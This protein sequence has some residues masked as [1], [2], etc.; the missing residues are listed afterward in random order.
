MLRANERRKWFRP[1][2]PCEK[3]NVRDLGLRSFHELRPRLSHCGAFSP[4]CE[5]RDGT[6][7]LL[8]T[9]LLKRDRLEAG[10][11]FEKFGGGT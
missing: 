1:S 4:I 2:R 3:S 8:K 11:V 5:I 6:A 9:N 7:S 10:Q